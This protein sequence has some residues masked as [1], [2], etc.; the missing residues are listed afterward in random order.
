[1]EELD[2]DASCASAEQR[3]VG[4]LLPPHEWPIKV[5]VLKPEIEAEV[6]A[7][8]ACTVAIKAMVLK[9]FVCNNI[10]PYLLPPSKFANLALV[11]NPDDLQVPMDLLLQDSLLAVIAAIRR[12]H[13][14]AVSAQTQSRW[15]MDGYNLMYHAQGPLPGP[16]ASCKA[17]RWQSSR[18]RSLTS[19][20]RSSGLGKRRSA[21][22]LSTSSRRPPF[23]H[24]TA[25]CMVSSTL[26]CRPTS[27]RWQ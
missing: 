7:M 4:D 22:R 2:C 26:W 24:K 18:R 12:L 11:L 25:L 27:L 3:C 16:F 10:S 5:K 8:K 19:T 6:L 9:L 21:Q 20:T 13:P 1:M 17:A 23:F 14:L 15:L